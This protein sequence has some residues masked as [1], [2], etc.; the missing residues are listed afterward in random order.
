[1]YRVILSVLV[2][3]ADTPL[4]PA[5]VHLPRRSKSPQRPVYPSDCIFGCSESGSRADRQPTIL[6]CGLRTSDSVPLGLLIS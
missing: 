6:K 2:A 3:M 5:N 1:M 4:G